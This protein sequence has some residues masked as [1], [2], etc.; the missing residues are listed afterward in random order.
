[1]G[2]RQ[3]QISATKMF[4]TIAGSGGLTSRMLYAS[5]ATGKSS[6]CRRVNGWELVDGSSKRRLK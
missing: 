6:F 3:Y 5:M 2:M 1:M 4:M